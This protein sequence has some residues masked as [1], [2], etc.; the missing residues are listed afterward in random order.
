MFL[1]RLTC[2]LPQYQVLDIVTLVNVFVFGT[3]EHT[4]VLDGGNVNNC[5]CLPNK[6]NVGENIECFYTSTGS[7]SDGTIQNVSVSAGCQWIRSDID[8]DDKHDV[9][10]VIGMINYIIGSDYSDIDELCEDGYGGGD[11]CT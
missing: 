11:A 7:T 6:M 1:G 9:L 5:A 2:F 4:C 3:S 10:D 8:G